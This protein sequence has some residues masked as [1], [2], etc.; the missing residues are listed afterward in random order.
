MNISNI[1]NKVPIEKRPAFMLGMVSSLLITVVGLAYFIVMLIMFMNG[2]MT[3]PPA[4][5]IQNFAAIVSIISAPL[6]IILCSSIHY[7]TPTR[8]KVFSLLG[9]AF[10]LIFAAFVCMN[11]FIQLSIVRLSILEG[12]MEGIYRFLPY[13]PRSAMFVMEMIGWGVFLGLALLFLAFTVKN[14]GLGK[15]IR[16]TFLLY[17]FLGMT[18]AISFIVDSP[19]SIIG[20][21]AWGL[22]LYIGTGLTAISFIKFDKYW[23][24]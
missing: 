4:E 20:F 23:D 17:G 16:Y 22:I 18:S 15:S 1:I 10:S 19:L 14:K 21:A 7:L 9:I 2:M 13:E 24:E 12:N 5:K 3:L 11:R 8:R 6:I